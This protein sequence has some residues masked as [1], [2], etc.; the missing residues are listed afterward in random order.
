MSTASGRQEESRRPTVW[1]VAAEAGVSKTT[2][3][4][5]LTGSPRVSPEAKA[6]VERAIETL[7]YVPNRAARSLVTRRTDTIALVVSEP[8]TRLFSEP[9]FAGTVR[10]INQELTTPSCFSRASVI[11][12]AS[13][14]TSEMGMQTALS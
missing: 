9:Y 1:G 13:S 14:V 11:A 6:A 8:E 10:G 4:R 7:G 5:V 3:S 12:A 2:V